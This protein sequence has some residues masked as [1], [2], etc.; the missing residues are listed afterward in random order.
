MK[1]IRTPALSVADV[2]RAAD[3][4]GMS[5]GKYVQQIE[6]GRSQA[7]G[8]AAKPDTVAKPGNTVIKPGDADTPERRARKQPPAPPAVRAA[9]VRAVLAGECSVREAAKRTGYPRASVYWWLR[10]AQGGRSRGA[11]ATHKY[12]KASPEAKAEAVR[13]VMAG[14][15]TVKEAAA[16]IGVCTNTVYLWLKKE[17]QR[18]EGR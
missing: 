14:E 5:Y 18:K 4:A 13:T 11:D 12:V 3:A 8:T 9:A 10:V 7:S 16:A 1:Q 17:R 6:K 15:L 2:A